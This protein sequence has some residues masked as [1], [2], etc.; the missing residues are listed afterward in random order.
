MADERAPRS[1]EPGSTPS[2]RRRDP[3]FEPARRLAIAARTF[4]VAAADARDLGSER[5]QTFLLLD[6]DGAGLAI[7][8]LSNA[9]EDPGTLDME[10]LAVLHAQRVDPGPAAGAPLARARRHGPTAPRRGAPRSSGPDGRPPRARCTTSCPAASGSTRATCRTRRSAAWGETTARLGRALRG[11]FRPGRCSGRC[12]GTS[13]TPRGPASSLGAIR[14]AGQ[15]ALVERVLDR[16]EAVVAPV[17]PGAP[18][19]GRAHG[20]DHRQRPRRRRRPDHRDRR[21]RRHEPHGAAG[22]PRG[23]CSIRCSTSRTG[24]SSSARP[25]WSSTATSG[26]RRSSRS[27]CGSSA[28]CVATRA[29]VTIAIS[30]WRSAQGLEDPGVRR[31]LQRDGG[32][33]D[34]RP[35]STPAGTRSRAGSGPR[36]RPAARRAALVDRRAA[37]LGPALEPLTYDEPIHMVEA[38]RRLDDRRRRAPLPRCLQQRPVRRPRPSRGSPRRSPARR[39]RLN[40]NLRYLHESAIELAERLIATC[41]PGPRHRVLRQLGLGGERPR[42]AAGDDGHRP[43]RRAVHGLR[44]PRHLRGDRR[45]LARDLAGRPRAGPRRDVGGRRTACAGTDLDGGAFAG[46]DRRARRR[47]ARRRPRSSSTAS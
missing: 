13:S 7:M 43:A 11:F 22:R 12:S 41:P 1:S 33:H 23:R 35:C 29:A 44:L 18:R 16:F 14:D 3:T 34:R 46:G 9:A 15:R 39:R 19:A 36:C 37:A 42:V 30:S 24:T 17:W 20:P 40:T 8:K 10:A 45:A 6:A 27:S 28:S 2:S 26:S 47:G 25:G 5:D 32:A 4:G 31:A 38:A 21:L